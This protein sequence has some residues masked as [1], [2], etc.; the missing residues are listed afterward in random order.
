[1]SERAPLTSKDIAECE[2]ALR[3]HRRLVGKPLTV[4]VMTWRL[5]AGAGVPMVDIVP[6]KAG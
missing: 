6:Y 1:M 5:L 2:L 3:K 4:G